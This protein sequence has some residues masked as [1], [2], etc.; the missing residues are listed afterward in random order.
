MDT[1]I[2]TFKSCTDIS[3]RGPVEDKTAE[4]HNS[5]EILIMCTPKNFQTALQIKSHAVDSTIVLVSF[6]FCH[7][8]NHIIYIVN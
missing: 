1:R 5:A 7:Q 4:Q 2:Q 3:S 8:I 6:F